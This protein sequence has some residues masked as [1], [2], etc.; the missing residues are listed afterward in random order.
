MSNGQE[1]AIRK[2]M[3]AIRDYSTVTRELYRDLETKYETRIGTLED[4]V[5]LLTTQIQS[6]QVKLFSGGATS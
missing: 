2:N 4:Q 1:D 5:K 6:L 3:M